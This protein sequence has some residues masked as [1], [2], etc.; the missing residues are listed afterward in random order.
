[1]TNSLLKLTDI[2]MITDNYQDDV[3]FKLKQKEDV[4]EIHFLHLI[5][6]LENVEKD[7]WMQINGNSS[8]QDICQ[9]LSVEYEADIGEI[10]NDVLDFMNTLLE[11]KLIKIV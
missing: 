6:F 2:V 8:I 1:M 4:I 7:I 10:E 5:Y 11:R 9:V 3:N